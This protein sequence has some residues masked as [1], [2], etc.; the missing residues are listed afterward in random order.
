MGL[1]VIANWDGCSNHLWALP[2]RKT[3][4]KVEDPWG[5]QNS[6]HGLKN[7]TISPWA[8]FVGDKIKN[9]AQKPNWLQS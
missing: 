9:G 5:K 4:C 3:H 8:L 6:D 1:K 2:D 7:L